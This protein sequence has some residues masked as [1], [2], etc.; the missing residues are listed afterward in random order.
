MK[1]SDTNYNKE[2]REKRERT[3]MHIKTLITTPPAL[4]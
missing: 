1:L 2:K 4:M 3:W